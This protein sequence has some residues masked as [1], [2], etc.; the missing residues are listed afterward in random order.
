M[1]HKHDT[2]TRVTPCLQHPGDWFDPKRRTFTRQGCLNCPNLLQCSQS[3]LRTQPSYGMWAGVWIDGDFPNKKHLL[4]AHA[5]PAADAKTPDRQ[6]ITPP[7]TPSGRHGRPGRR[8]RVGKLLTT[9]PRPAIAAQIT[10]R[11][12]GHCEIMAPACTYSQAAIFSRRRRANPR[13]LASPA[14]AIAACHNCIELIEHSRHPHRARP[15]IPRRPTHHHQ[16]RRDVVAPTPVGLPRH[17]RAHPRHRRPSSDPHR[18]LAMT[19]CLAAT[20]STQPAAAWKALA[21]LIAA[22]PIIRVWNPATNKFDRTKNLTSRLPQVPAAAMIYLRGLTQL[23]ALDFD[24]KHRGRDA[25]DADFTRALTWITEAGGVA[26][27]DRSSSGGRHI[28]VPLAIGTSAT[29]AEITTS[30]ACSRPGCPPS[31]KPPCPTRKPDVS[32]CPAQPAAKAAT[33]PSMAI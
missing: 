14:D 33:A 26:V 6:P 8:I 17:P 28:L 32:P 2:D 27:T 12:S 21:P 20:T 23:L 11:A 1:N 4:G 30:C 10:A 24:A 22:R 9:S 29:L 15:R 31:T 5:R 19:T 25:V 18:L 7:D 3:A 13:P 16:H